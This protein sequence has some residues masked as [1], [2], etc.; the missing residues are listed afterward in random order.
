MIHKKPKFGKGRGAIVG[1]YATA[2]DVRGNVFEDDMTNDEVW[3]HA[4][5]YTKASSRGPFADIITKG[6]EAENWEAYGLK[7]VIHRICTRKLDLNTYFGQA[8]MREFSTGLPQQKPPVIDDKEFRPEDP[9]F[10]IGLD[11]DAEVVDVTP[12]KKSFQPTPE[13][14]AEIIAQESAEAEQQEML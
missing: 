6:P 11:D 5:R 13:E 10:E 12:E 8:L 14:E 3:E 9:V 4:K 7:T 1:F 2:K